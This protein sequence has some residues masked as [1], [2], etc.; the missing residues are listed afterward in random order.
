MK[1]TKLAGGVVL[2]AVA[3]LAVY[4]LTSDRTKKQRE[5]L[6][7]WALEMK[8][9]LIKKLKN[10]KDIKKEDYEKMVSDLSK[11]YSKVS[12]V[13]KKEFD[14]VISDIRDGWK[15]IKKAI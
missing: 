4:F 2:G 15:H 14:K 12:R 11:K 3:A 13:G 7:K 10:M 5:H 9:E 6:A 8:A 1:K